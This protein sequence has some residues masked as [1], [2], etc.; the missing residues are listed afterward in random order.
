MPRRNKYEQEKNT[1]TPLEGQ[2]PPEMMHFSDSK[3]IY[4][5]S[6]DLIDRVKCV[7][8][9]KYFIFKIGNFLTEYIFLFKLSFV[10]SRNRR[11]KLVKGVYLDK[12]EIS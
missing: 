5:L 6:Q 12:Q 1:K 10:F 9:G 11:R 4:L 7:S 8:G 3:T 2:I